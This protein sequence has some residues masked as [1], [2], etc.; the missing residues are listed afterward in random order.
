MDFWVSH[1]IAGQSGAPNGL[2]PR[3]LMEPV[4]PNIRVMVRTLAGVT[5]VDC[6]WLIRDL[7]LDSDR[8][9]TERGCQELCM[10]CMVFRFELKWL[11]YGMEWEN[12]AHPAQG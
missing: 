5:G 9:H 3:D 11:L 7:P 2:C 4:S 6:Q 10:V 8:L 1:G 12:P